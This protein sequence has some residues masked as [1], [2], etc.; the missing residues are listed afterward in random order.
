MREMIWALYET[1]T[2][3]L[4]A[5]N[6]VSWETMRKHALESV[7]SGEYSTRYDYVLVDETQ[8]F[9]PVALALLAELSKEAQGIFMA[10]DTKQSIHTKGTPLQSIHPR[11]R[12]RGRTRILRRN[13]RSTSQI[14]AAAFAMLPDEDRETESPSDCVHEGPLPV[15]VSCPSGPEEAKWAARCVR[16]MAK[17][18]RL[19]PGAAGVLVPD[20]RIGNLVAR[21]MSKEGVQARYFKGN[22]LDLTATE[23]KVLTLHSAKG[24]EF[25]IVVL[26]GLGEGTYP[27][28]EPYEEA[29]FK[30]RLDDY[31]RLLYVGLTRA[32]RGLM[33]IGPSNAEN[34]AIKALDLKLWN[35][36][37]EDVA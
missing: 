32:M 22:E 34:P 6:M 20:S 14:E 1:L 29:E 16:Q 9:S 18:L 24:L 10:A 37:G 2:E 33:L 23:V 5:R 31:R 21:E 27:D 15:F 25:P 35:T 3:H 17:H 36:V 13:Y 4:S 28:P 7:K 26:C 19:K 30:E 8:D 12:F 11:L